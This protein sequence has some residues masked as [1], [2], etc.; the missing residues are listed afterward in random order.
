VCAAQRVTGDLRNRP[1]GCE[2]TIEL[3][4]AAVGAKIHE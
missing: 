1:P 2:V 3:P 4:R